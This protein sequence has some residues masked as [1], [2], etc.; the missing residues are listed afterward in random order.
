MVDI[1]TIVY[2]LSYNLGLLS[3]PKAALLWPEATK[4]P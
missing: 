2:Y 4:S 1:I 3:I